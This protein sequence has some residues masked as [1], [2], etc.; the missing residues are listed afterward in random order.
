MATDKPRFSVT[1]TDDSFKKIQRY[2][3]ENNI[4]TKSNVVALLVYIE[5]PKI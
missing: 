5:I 1:F 4:R 2:K 3:K